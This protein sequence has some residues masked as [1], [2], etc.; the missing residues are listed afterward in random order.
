VFGEGLPDF[1][2]VEQQGAAR[3]TLLVQFFRQDTNGFIA[4]NFGFAIG[5]T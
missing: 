2:R 4:G 3:A 1:S 5:G